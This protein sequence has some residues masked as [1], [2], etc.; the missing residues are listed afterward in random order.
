[1][2]QTTNRDELTPKIS[3][4]LKNFTPAIDRKTINS[5]KSIKQKI[6]ENNLIVTK[7]DKSDAIVVIPKPDY[8]SKVNK[9]LETDQIKLITTDPTQKFQKI[10][11]QA[12]NESSPSTLTKPANYF[13]NMNPSAPKLYGLIK[14]HKENV[15]IR[16]VVSHI[17]S[18]CYK[19]A[20][21]L[22]HI[23]RKITGFKS[24]YSIKNSV[25]L[26]QKLKQI[27]LPPNCTLVS[28][29]VDDMFSNIPDKECISIISDIMDKCN[30]DI[31]THTDF[32]FLLNICTQQN[33]F[34]FDNKFYEQQQGL[35]MGSPLSPLLADIFMDHFENKLFQIIQNNKILFW[36]RYVDDVLACFSGTSRQLDQFL[37]VL[38]NIHP[39]I[40]F[41]LETE[42]DNKI[43]FLD[44]TIFH[45]N[46]N[47]EFDIYRKPTHTDVCIP[48]DSI[49]PTTYKLSAYRSFIHRAFS[50]PLSKENFEKEILNIKN[51][52][53]NNGFDSNIIDRLVNK[54][55][56]HLAY[57]S[58]Y[59]SITQKLDK[60]FISLSYFGPV[61]DRLA[62]IIS[63]SD[64]NIFIAFKPT[65]NLTNYFFNC[66]D[67]VS[68][69]NHS[70]VY[71]IS[72]PDC[73][74]IYIGQ[75]GRSF[76][77]RYKEHSNSFKK[78]KNDSTIA[79][80][81]RDNQHKFAPLDNLQ[82][83]HRVPK[84]SKLNLL[85]SL[86]IFKQKHNNEHCLLNDQVDL[87]YSPL[88]EVFRNNST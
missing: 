85:E 53:R 66:K 47:L 88:F 70:G 10:I 28:F 80:H 63:K 83:L 18:P 75:T 60:K 43:N 42:I 50:I 34:Q 39:N 22:T 31:T 24:K 54:K 44:L 8:F 16:P 72:C 15:P 84:S 21:E 61:S 2:K 32:I 78:N 57:H 51:I 46:N 29:D 45:K 5:M 23:F 64:P 68:K 76:N 79:T 11:K 12:I 25:E 48:L 6:N 87:W 81:C 77:T 33:Y 55:R 73:E 40:K 30:V 86:E 59:P 62:N 65:C 52:A 74:G 20:R 36:F 1:M 56:T 82:I 3:K 7:T 26:S 19:L 38:N 69:Y 13:I 67:S 49:H 27:S 14:N 58:I 41:K 35:P 9:F 37:N 71:K 4:E 17:N